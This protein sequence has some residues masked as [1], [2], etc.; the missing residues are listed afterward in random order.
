MPTALY[1]VS[2]E[3]ELLMPTKFDSLVDND[4]T[5]SQLNDLET[6]FLS[7]L[8]ALEIFNSTYNQLSPQNDMDIDNHLTIENGFSFY[9][10]HDFHK[11]C[12]NNLHNKGNA[13][14][15]LHSNTR[16][17]QKNT[18]QFETLLNKDIALISLA[19]LRYGTVAKTMTL[20][21]Q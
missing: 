8:P 7:D 20:F 14:P 3:T 15:F 12:S 6:K 19:S 13:L 1:S 17:Y 10:L 5:N 21:R 18:E 4:Y 2:K 9:K 11:L 16:S